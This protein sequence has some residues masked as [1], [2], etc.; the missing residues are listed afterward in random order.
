MSRSGTGLRIIPPGQRPSSARVPEK[1][2][3]NDLTLWDFVI[4]PSTFWTRAAWEKVGQLDETLHYV[5]DWDWFIRAKKAG[6]EFLGTE[7][8]LSIYRI[9]AAHKSGSADQRR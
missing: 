9:H 3:E 6:V 8:A 5:F 2:A 7:R 4:Q 1:L